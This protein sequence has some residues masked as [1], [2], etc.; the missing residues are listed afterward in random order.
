MAYRPEL[1][2]RGPGVIWPTGPSGRCG[3]IWPTGGGVIREGSFGLPARVGGVR[4]GSGGHLAYRPEWEASGVWGSFGLPARVGG[5][6]RGHLAYRP[7]LE[8]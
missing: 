8:V 2:V 3:V 4:Q 7:E 5:V 6:I 1:E